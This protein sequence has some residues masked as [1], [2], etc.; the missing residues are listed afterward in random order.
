[1][2]ICYSSS[3]IF[4]CNCNRMPVTLLEDFFFFKLGLQ[5]IRG[6]CSLGGDIEKLNVICVCV[7]ILSFLLTI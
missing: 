4:N 1:M 6:V 7:K 5:I 3:V 2:L